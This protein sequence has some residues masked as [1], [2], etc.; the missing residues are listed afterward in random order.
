[1]GPL[2]PGSQTD[3]SAM[4]RSPNPF[5]PS[6][7]LKASNPQSLKAAKLQSLKSLKPS[8]PSNPQTLKPSNPQTLKPSNPQTLK[9]SN[10]RIPEPDG[11]TLARDGHA[12]P[13][14][15]RVSLAEPPSTLSPESFNPMPE[16]L[17]PVLPVGSQSAETSRDQFKL[18]RRG[19]RV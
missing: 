3:L 14:R 4:R 16:T 2:K 9:P 17:N 13:V 10:P 12:T 15:G 8:N 18:G 1:M 5:K 11:R 19:F 6:K 7:I